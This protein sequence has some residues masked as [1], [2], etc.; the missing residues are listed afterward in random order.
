MTDLITNSS[1]TIFTYSEGSEKVVIE[2]IDE[3]FKTFGIDKKCEDVFDVVVL[4]EKY[5]YTENLD[6]WSEDE[7]KDFLP[8]GVTIENIDQIYDDVASG[9]VKKPEFFDKIEEMENSYNYFTPSTYLHLIP[10]GEEY[11]NLGALIHNF[12]YSTH[13]EGTYDG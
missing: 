9:K 3:F 1:T 2:M 11:A 7:L 12:L 6:R 8:E 13:H 5:E 4:A 10:K